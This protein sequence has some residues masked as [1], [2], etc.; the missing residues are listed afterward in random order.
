MSHNAGNAGLEP[1]ADKQEGRQTVFSDLL[2]KRSSHTQVAK[3]QK[4]KHEVRK[5]TSLL[6]Q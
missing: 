1:N 4:Q 6:G 2:M 3:A 5:V